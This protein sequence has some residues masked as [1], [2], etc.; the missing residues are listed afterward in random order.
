M[1]R[2]RTKLRLTTSELAQIS[3]R[4]RATSDLR[5]RERLQFAR[6]AATGRYT[7]EELATLGGRSRSTI[8]NWLVKFAAGGLEGLL[9]R[10][11]PPGRVSPIAQ[12]AIQRQL[13][14]GLRTG[15]RKT[16]AELAGWLKEHH[17]IRR[18][19]KSIYYWMPKRADLKLQS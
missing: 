15:R 10:D 8:Q 5:Q 11:T 4:I 9:E 1:G 17:G 7:L 19:P 2:K 3:G 14:S 12:P 16:A 18:K 6:L 13:T